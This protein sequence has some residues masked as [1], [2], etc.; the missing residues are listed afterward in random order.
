MNSRAEAGLAASLALVKITVEVVTKV[1]KGFAKVLT[2]ANMGVWLCNGTH[3]GQHGGGAL[4][5]YH[6]G[7][8]GGGRG[9]AEVLQ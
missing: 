7:Q 1:D 6:Y 4:Q 8:Y 9:F 3:F 5:M 2:V